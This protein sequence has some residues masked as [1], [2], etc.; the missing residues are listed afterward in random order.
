M[1][2]ILISNLPEE[3]TKRV[4]RH[5]RLFSVT[6]LIYDDDI[7]SAI[8]CAGTVC[9]IGNHHGIVS[10]NHVWNELKR[11]KEL[12]IM[13]SKKGNFGI[14][15]RYITPYSLPPEGE[16]KDYPKLEVP[17]LV[18]M[19][20]PEVEV[21]TIKAYD[22]VF[23][24]IDVHQDNANFDITKKAGYWITYGSS[25]ELLK[26]EKLETTY[27][28]FSTEQRQGYAYKDWDYVELEIF[29]TPGVMPKSLGGMS[30][31]GIWNV[32]FNVDQTK[33]PMKFSVEDWNTDIRFLGVNIYQ[34]P[35]KN[36]YSQ[37][38]AHGP[39]SIYKRLVDYI[40][41]NE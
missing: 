4:N 23:Y 8:P 21:S 27:I 13:I 30:G 1:D 15:R 16:L 41:K 24:P 37:I 29:H 26:P 25:S 35:I 31:G 36:K 10:A 2:K 7:S 19:Q 9:K 3:L 28:L 20:I 40:S 34:T 6:M 12:K 39:Q 22:K 14:E 18:F 5:I 32:K 33:K 17:D 11:H 38:I